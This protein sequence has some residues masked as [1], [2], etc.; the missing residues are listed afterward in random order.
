MPDNPAL[1]AALQ[2]VVAPFVAAL[3]VAAVLSRSRFAWLAIVV[4]YGAQVALAT[5]FSFSPLSA[6]RK[7]LLLCLLAPAVGIAVDALAPRT[8]AVAYALAAVAGIAAVW[9]FTTLLAQKEGAQAWLAGLGIFVFAAAMSAALVALRDRPLRTGAA[10]L[11]LGL[12]TGI[13]GL[14]SAS[15]G[16]FTSGLAVAAASGA[17][18]LVWVINARPVKP[19]LLGTLSIGVMIALFAE[20]SLMLAKLPWYALVTLLLVPVAAGLPID[21]SWSAFR[22][23][24]VLSLYALAAAAIPVAAVWFAPGG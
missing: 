14:M 17:L 24:F 16:F 1:Q 11:G 3:V 19:G 10:G 8:R 5:G 9:A 13:T 7:I 22:R 15:V 21:K 23:A 6:S 12:A 20:G 2:G 4:G 18:L